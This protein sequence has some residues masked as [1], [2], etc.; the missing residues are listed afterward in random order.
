[1]IVPSRVSAGETVQV[2]L[3][4]KNT[5]SVQGKEVVQCYVA[6]KVS[7]LARP[8]KELKAF[9]KVDLKPG[10]TKIVKFSLDLRAFAFYD[11]Y[12]AKW[13]AEPGEF[14]ILVGS[15]SQDIRLTAGLTL[16]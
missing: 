4:V 8:L 3:I 2:S 13:I 15:S 11:P 10:E 14:D 1:M 16:A 12:A 7:S 5:G 9:A 6:D